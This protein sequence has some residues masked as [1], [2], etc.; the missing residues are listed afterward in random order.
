MGTDNP[1]PVP[2]RGGSQ[3]VYRRKAEVML[4]IRALERRDHLQRCTIFWTFACITFGCIGCALIWR[5]LVWI[6]LAV[7]CGYF[8]H[9][10]K[11]EAR[12]MQ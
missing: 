9:G 11:Q 1:R 12:E 10:S 6:F 8:A 7:I 3:H 4:T 2:D 5:P